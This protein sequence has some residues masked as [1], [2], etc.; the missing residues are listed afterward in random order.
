MARRKME[1]GCTVLVGAA[2]TTIG[3]VETDSETEPAETTDPELVDV[4]SKGGD[5]GA[6]EAQGGEVSHSSVRARFGGGV[7]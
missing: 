4:T 2:V 6:A 7:Q 1:S 5:A 3:V